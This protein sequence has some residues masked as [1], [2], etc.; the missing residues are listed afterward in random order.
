MIS[1]KI[2]TYVNAVTNKPAYYILVGNV[3]LKTLKEIVLYTRNFESALFTL[4]R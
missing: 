4:H 3:F 1:S 2:T